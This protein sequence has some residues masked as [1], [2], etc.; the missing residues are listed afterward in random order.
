M[1]KPIHRLIYYYVKV[2]LDFDKCYKAKETREDERE[3]SG[4]DNTWSGTRENAR[5]QERQYKMRS[6]V[7]Q[8]GVTL[9]GHLDLL[10]NCDGFQVVWGT[11]WSYL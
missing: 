11:T 2:A 8:I 6:E 5:E 1:N 3:I 10:S 4:R 7:G 9:I